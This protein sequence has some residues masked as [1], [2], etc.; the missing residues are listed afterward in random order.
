MIK[1]R[2]SGLTP[3]RKR[4]LDIIKRLHRETGLSPSM[5][6]VQAAAGLASVATVAE[7]INAL[8]QLGLLENEQG[9]RTLLPTECDSAADIY[10]CEIPFV[11]FFDTTNGL[12]TLSKLQLITMPRSLLSKPQSTYALQMNGNDLFSEGICDGD[13]LLVEVHA[14]YFGRPALIKGPQGWW[15]KRVQQ[16]GAYLCLESIAAMAEPIYHNPDEIEIF[17][18]LVASWRNYSTSQRIIN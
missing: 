6:E 7:H 3:K 17:A 4:I 11:G 9:R 2:H 14:D 12:E 1:H 10:T 13:I 18:V 5:R 15:L 16:S 8:K